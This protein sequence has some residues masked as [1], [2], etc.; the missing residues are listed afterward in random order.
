VAPV[1]SRD[2]EEAGIDI[3]IVTSI[4]DDRDALADTVRCMTAANPGNLEWI[5]V[6]GGST[7]GSVELGRSVEG[8]PVTQIVEPDDGIYDAWNK[9]LACARG[10]WVVFLGAGDELHPG[11]ISRLAG[12]PDDVGFVYG[13]LR[14]R[15]GDWNRLV[16]SSS[17][18]RAVERMGD[19]MPIPHVGT[20]HAGWLFATEG[21]DSGLRILGDWEFVAR[22]VEAGGRYLGIEQAT[23]ALGGISNRPRMAAVRR[24]E[25]RLVRERHGLSVTRRR[26][27][28]LM[29]KEWLGRVPAIHDLVQRWWHGSRSRR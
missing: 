26:R 27:A 10:R 23:M 2:S 8:I 17:W 5:L 7:D 25:R 4:L 20:A 15:H 9:G 16:R 19:G 6:D 21:F 24:R 28:Q 22:R 11:W 13:D 18:E 14:L 12:E 3:S 1:R 29:M